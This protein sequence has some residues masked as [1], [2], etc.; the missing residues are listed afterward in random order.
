[1]VSCE[2]TRS[3]IKAR[4]EF[5]CE[6]GKVMRKLGSD[7]DEVLHTTFG[8]IAEGNINVAGAVERGGGGNCPPSPIF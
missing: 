5:L 4:V 8:K 1:M 7:G 3:P 2:F 6:F